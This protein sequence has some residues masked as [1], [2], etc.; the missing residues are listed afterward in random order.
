MAAGRPRS[1]DEKEVLDSAMRCFWQRG[2]E[3]T[4]YEDLCAETGL[5][6]PSLYYAFGSKD[7]LFAAALRRYEEMFVTPALDRLEAD[8]DGRRAAIGYVMDFI[9]KLTDP[10]TPGGCLIASNQPELSGSD[11]P[12]TARATMADIVTRS[13]ATLCAAIARADQAGQLP[14]GVARE[15]MLA[16]LDTLLAGIASMARAGAGQQDLARAA[17]LALTAWP[18]S[19]G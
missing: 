15:D 13:R 4:S 8:P 5:N 12:E 16:F 18:V 7:E 6:K 11:F 17:T 2:F 19:E 1:F 3:G 9:D 14:T 10:A